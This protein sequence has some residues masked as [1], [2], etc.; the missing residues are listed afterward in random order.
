MESDSDER[1]TPDTFLNA[2][3]E[4]LTGYDCIDMD[5]AVILTTHILKAAPA[6]NAVAEAR[7][8]IL[9][10]ATERAE[11]PRGESVDG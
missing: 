5:L 6:A 7:D 1:E 10:L 8:A 2:L 4:S 9:R 3:G 11:L